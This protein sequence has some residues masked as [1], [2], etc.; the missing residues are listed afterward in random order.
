MSAIVWSHVSIVTLAHRLR[1]HLQAAPAAPPGAAEKATFSAVPLTDISPSSLLDGAT[2]LD[3]QEDVQHTLETE[4]QQAAVY[5]PVVVS[6]EQTPDQ[7]AAALEPS[8][9]IARSRAPGVLQSLRQDKQQ[10]A[11][12]KSGKETTSM[13]EFATCQAAFSILLMYL[14]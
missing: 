4:Q 12:S 11:N 2:P 14:M 13:T 5:S 1:F 7:F 9:N 8:G 6:P 10:L 3:S